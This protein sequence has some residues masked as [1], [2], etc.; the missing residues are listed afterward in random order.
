MPNVI[1]HDE[2]MPSNRWPISMGDSIG[3]LLR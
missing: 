3:A 2:K 1:Q